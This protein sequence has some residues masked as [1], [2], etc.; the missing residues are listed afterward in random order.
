M[1]PGAR[2][3]FVGGPL[4]LGSALGLLVGLGF[5]MLLMLRI[6][7]RRAL[8]ARELDGLPGVSGQGA[9]PPGVARVVSGLTTC[10]RGRPRGTRR[11]PDRPDLLGGALVPR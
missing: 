2:V 7:A 4:L 5:V 9:L 1:Y 10:E 3:M 8:S 11:H 6:M